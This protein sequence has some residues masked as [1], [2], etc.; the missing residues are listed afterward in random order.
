MASVRAGY[1]RPTPR[2]VF[3]GDC[4]RGQG[5]GESG[6]GGGG[7]DGGGGDGGAGADDSDDG[8]RVGEAALFALYSRLRAAVGSPPRLRG[9][10]GAAA[11]PSRTDADTAAPAAAGQPPPFCYI[12]EKAAAGEYQAAK[13]ALLDAL[14]QRWLR[15]R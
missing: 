12:S 5:Q 9:G 1:L 6:G 10:G 14:P 13:A 2:L 11:G 7:G 8:P 3:R 4:A 15:R